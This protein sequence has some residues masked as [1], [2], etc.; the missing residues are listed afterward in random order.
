MFNVCQN[1]KK[2]NFSLLNHDIIKT[3]SDYLEFE[4][5]IRDPNITKNA[6]QIYILGAIE[7][8]KTEAKLLEEI[9]H[10][11]P[12]SSDYGKK[13]NSLK[14]KQAELNKLR[15]AFTAIGTK[16]SRPTSLE[17]SRLSIDQ[18]KI[19]PRISKLMGKAE[20]RAV[21]LD[22]NVMVAQKINNSYMIR[23]E[24]VEQRYNEIKKMYL[25]KPAKEL[26]S[27]L[28]DVDKE[29]KNPKLTAASLNKLVSMRMEIRRK[30]D[31]VKNNEI[32]KKT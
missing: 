10:L 27:I 24:T 11:K 20:K 23:K 8:E 14:E 18:K 17:E 16:I 1:I 2:S 29:L 5:N 7:H 25:L 4:D 22:E 12:S 21:N 13:L 32:F 15:N 3:I 28:N 19:E 30:L 6:R 26:E 9:N 31:L